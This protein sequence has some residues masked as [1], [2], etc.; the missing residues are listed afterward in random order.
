VHVLENTKF[1]PGTNDKYKHCVVSCKIALQCGS[2]VSGAAGMGKE[3]GDLFGPGNAE[4]S[5]LVADYRGLQCAAQIK[6]GKENCI[7]LTCE[8]CCE[9]VGP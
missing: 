3:I 4:W 9:G 1:A 6:S 8:E 7:G 5:D 2:F